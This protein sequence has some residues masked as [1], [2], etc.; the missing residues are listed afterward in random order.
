M[1]PIIT[2]F[3]NHRFVRFV[4]HVVVDGAMGFVVLG[5]LQLF[6]VEMKRME[7]WGYPAD[8]LAYFQRVHFGTSFAIFVMF[9]VSLLYRVGA[10]IL[11]DISK[12]G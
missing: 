9:S 5:S 8:E 2:R 11:K 4:R 7:I 10:D 1:T 6:F 3:W 12:E